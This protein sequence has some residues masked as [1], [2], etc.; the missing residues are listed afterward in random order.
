[1]GDWILSNAGHHGSL[2]VLVQYWLSI[3]YVLVYNFDDLL[4]ISWGAKSGYENHRGKFIC[5]LLDE[6]NASSL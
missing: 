5:H 4:E 3:N 6:A 2:H 1:M